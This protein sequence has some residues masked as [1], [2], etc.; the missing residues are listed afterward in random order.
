MEEGVV[1]SF[2][3]AIRDLFYVAQFEGVDVFS[4]VFTLVF[5]TTVAAV[6]FAWRANMKQH[7]HRLLELSK[8]KVLRENPFIET[9]VDRLEKGQYSGATYCDFVMDLHCAGLHDLAKRA[10]EGNF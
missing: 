5:A 6:F 2:G 1:V 8:A 9:I 3:R 4:I 7:A 10:R